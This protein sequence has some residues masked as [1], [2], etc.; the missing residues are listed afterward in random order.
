MTYLK[1]REQLF[2]CL[3]PL[4]YAPIS[5][6][7]VKVTLTP[8]PTLDPGHEDVKKHLDPDSSPTVLQVQVIRG[9]HSSLS[10]EGLI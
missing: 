6:D 10:R 9:R 8:S 5:H 4:T 7:L 2:E 3:S 1:S